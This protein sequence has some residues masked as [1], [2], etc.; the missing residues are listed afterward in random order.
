MT[1]LIILPREL[2]PARN[3]FDIGAFSC[4]GDFFWNACSK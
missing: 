1:G 2:Q 3:E 4:R